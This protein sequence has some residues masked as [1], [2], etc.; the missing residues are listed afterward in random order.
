M[1]PREKLI[2]CFNCKN[3]LA[4]WGLLEDIP[5][6]KSEKDFIPQH[7]SVLASFKNL[8]DEIVNLG[9]YFGIFS[10]D[11]LKTLSFDKTVSRRDVYQLVFVLAALVNSSNDG[12]VCP[13]EDYTDEH[14]FEFEEK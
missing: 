10:M 4:C 7:S 3:N 14:D 2:Q 5:L 13:R 11:C 8:D 9:E 6:G 12:W 1:L